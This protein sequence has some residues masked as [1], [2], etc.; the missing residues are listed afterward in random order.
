MLGIL[1][2]AKD[3][4]SKDERHYLIGQQGSGRSTALL[5][6]V[7]QALSTGWTVIYLSCA[8]EYINSSSPITYDSETQ[9]FLQPALSRSILQSIIKSNETLKEITVD[10]QTLNNHANA[11]LD[12]PNG[13]ST[14]L[15]ILAKSET[16]VLLAIDS[17]QS[18]FRQSDYLKPDSITGRIDSFALQI[19]RVLL[20]YATGQ[21]TFK[22][23]CLLSGCGSESSQSRA[24]DL[25]SSGVKSGY[26]DLGLYGD[27]VRKANLKWFKM[28]QGM[29]RSE[30]GVWLRVLEEAKILRAR[31]G[32]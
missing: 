30:A 18:L 28:E 11:L 17:A 27:L 32:L 26:E 3:R 5:Q 1:N 29:S 24:V 10:D 7:D 21:K 22:G 4:S 9:T 8:T 16:P 25:V 13:L 12:Q 6:I 23:L 19:P 14:F 20:E 15:S 31:E 2:K